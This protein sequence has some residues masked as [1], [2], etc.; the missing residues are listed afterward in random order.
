M[1]RSYPR[2]VSQAARDTRS[3]PEV[4][5]NEPPFSLEEVLGDDQS[6]ET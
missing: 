5:T 1:L 3:P 4:F 6:V 2:A